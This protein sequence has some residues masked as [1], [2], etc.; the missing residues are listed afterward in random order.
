VSAETHRNRLR[1]ARALGIALG[2]SIDI[3]IDAAS[4]SGDLSSEVSLSDTPG[5]DAE[6]AL[7]V[8]GNTVSG[9]FR[10]FRV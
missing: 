3:D 4:A 10:V 7:V 5:D 6:P 8:R 2:T 1:R 9:D